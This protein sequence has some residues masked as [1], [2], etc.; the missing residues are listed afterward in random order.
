MK[1]SQEPQE[2]NVGVAKDGLSVLSWRITH[3]KH[4]LYEWTY[5]LCGEPPEALLCLGHSAAQ[6]AAGG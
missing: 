2:C 5:R 6:D 1:C 4:Y 3:G